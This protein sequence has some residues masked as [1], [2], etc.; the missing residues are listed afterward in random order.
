M[1]VST[2]PVSDILSVKGNLLE[3]FVK[4]VSVCFNQL[5]IKSNYKCN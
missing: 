5:Y 1:L 3:F 4:F 2:K